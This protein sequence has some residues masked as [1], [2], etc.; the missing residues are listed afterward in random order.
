MIEVF[1]W[2]LSRV[3]SHCVCDASFSTNHA[4]ICHHGGL[5]FI[6]HNELRGLTVSWLHE[7]CHDVVVEPPLQPL[8]DEA[9]VPAFANHSS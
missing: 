4:I 7:V 9:L 6:R 8:T 3:L 2:E 5:I 1:G